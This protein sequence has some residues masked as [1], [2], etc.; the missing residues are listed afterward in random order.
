M[1]IIGIFYFV[2]LPA[3]VLG[4]IVSIFLLRKINLGLRL[5]Y[6]FIIAIATGC[7]S[8]RFIAAFF[9]ERVRNQ[10][11]I[12]GVLA[13]VLV[14]IIYKTIKNKTVVTNLLNSKVA[15]IIVAIL[16]SFFIATILSTTS[17]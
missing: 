5:L 7:I 1:E 6:S 8:P 2:M 11:I 3:F 9:D 10:F 17:H 15:M 14:A 12:W 16:V 4:F 13:I